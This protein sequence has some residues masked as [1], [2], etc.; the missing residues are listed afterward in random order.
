MIKIEN[1]PAN[2]NGALTLDP[3]CLYAPATHG[4]GLY[5][6]KFRMI[7]LLGLIILQL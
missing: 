4:G 1:L 6:E 2:P 3:S 7:S 5:Q